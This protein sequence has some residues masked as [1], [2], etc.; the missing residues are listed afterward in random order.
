M[1]CYN[2]QGKLCKLCGVISLIGGAASKH[3]PPRKVARL[4]TCPLGDARDEVLQAHLE[5][6]ETI[7]AHGGLQALGL[8][9]AQTAECL[10]QETVHVQHLLVRGVA[11]HP[12]H[13]RAARADAL[14]H[15][16][17]AAQPAGHLLVVALVPSLHRLQQLA[18]LRLHVSYHLAHVR[19]DQLL[20]V[21]ARAAQLAHGRVHLRV[22]RA[23]GA[24]LLLQRLRHGVQLLLSLLDLRADLAVA[25][26]KERARAA[27]RLGTASAVDAV[28][29]QGRPRL[30]CSGAI[31]AHCNL[32]L[33]GSRDSCASASRV[34]GTTGTC[35][36]GTQLVYPWWAV[37]CWIM[38]L[39]QQV[40]G[41]LPRGFPVPPAIFMV[42]N[43]TT[44][45]WPL[46]DA[47]LSSMASTIFFLLSPLD[48]IFIYLKNILSTS[49]ARWL[50]PVIPAL[51]E[52]EAGGSPED[53][54]K[55]RWVDHLNSRVQ[56]QPHLHG[57][58]PSLLK[59]QKNG[60]TRLLIFMRQ[61]LA[62]LPRL[63]CSGMIMAHCSLNFS[64]SSNFPTLVPLVA[65]TTGVHHYVKSL[66]ISSLVK[67]CSKDW[68]QWLTPVIPALW[69]AQAG[70]PPELRSLRPA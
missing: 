50:T 62:V 46:P 29:T 51:W 45:Q 59:I 3:R 63:E 22:R 61:G 30:E 9:L 19:A 42:E 18:L 65:G 57:E 24:V 67:N 53:F 36:Q 5:L 66:L 13:E 8:L 20:D 1:I 55:P 47:S 21:S 2:T 34:A 28:D 6:V 70:G 68:A 48:L 12:L 26:V 4:L 58:T 27:Q 64:G 41:M 54:G 37:F 11:L 40:A 60:R 39:I 49:R 32:R 16:V 15:S 14:Q 38:S 69:E 44:I 25:A 7:R 17:Q 56:D 23:K 43:G 52:A 10:A 31:L 33:L 35:S